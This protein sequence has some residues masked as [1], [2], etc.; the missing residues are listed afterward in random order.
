MYENRAMWKRFPHGSIWII[1]KD[2]VAIF[3]KATGME[4]TKIVRQL[5]ELQQETEKL[6]QQKQL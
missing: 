6:S 3:Q 1:Y 2:M 4:K 5:E